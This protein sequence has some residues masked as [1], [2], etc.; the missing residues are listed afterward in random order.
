MIDSESSQKIFKL[1]SGLYL[2]LKNIDSKLD[3]ITEVTEV[4]IY[5]SSGD[6]R[7]DRKILK[8]VDKLSKKYI[9]ESESYSDPELTKH[10]FSVERKNVYNLSQDI[11]DGINDICMSMQKHFIES[12]ISHLSSSLNQR[13]MSLDEYNSNI[14][15]AINDILSRIPNI[16]KLRINKLHEILLKKYIN[17][18]KIKSTDTFWKDNQV[19][20]TIVKW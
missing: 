9:S 16:L 18:D 20:Q 8:R 5:E 2:T 10:P 14:E 1:L 15:K 13:K 6:V 4:N 11:E 3:K 12:R 17:K 7:T 19:N